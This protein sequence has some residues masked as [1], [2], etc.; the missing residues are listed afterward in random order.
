MKK[1]KFSDLAKLTKLEKAAMYI[2]AA[3]HD[4]DHPYFS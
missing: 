1:C 3:A 4:Y 2:A